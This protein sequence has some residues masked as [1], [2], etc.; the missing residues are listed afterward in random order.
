[1]LSIRCDSVKSAKSVQGVVFDAVPDWNK[2]LLFSVGDDRSL[3]VWRLDP[4]ST[5]SSASTASTTSCS[6]SSF[7]HE[8]RPWRVLPLYDDF[9][10]TIGE[11]VS[12]IHASFPILSDIGFQDET[13][14]FWSYSNDT[15]TLL[16]HK[17][18]HLNKGSIRSADFDGERMLLVMEFLRIK[19]PE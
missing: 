5:A 11:V 13:I 4:A 9:L 10:A 8:A 16:L 2:R 6:A 18:L 3:R 14:C 19:I 12:L 7:G 1:M 17:K 15:E